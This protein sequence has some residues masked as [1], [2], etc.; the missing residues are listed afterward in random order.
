MTA[1]YL[2]EIKGTKFDT[3]RDGEA[4]F[5]PCYTLST[6]VVTRTIDQSEQDSRVT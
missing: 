6:E 2:S 3:R 1:E 5:K 4:K